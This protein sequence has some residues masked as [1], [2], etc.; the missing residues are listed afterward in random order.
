[1]KLPIISKVLFPLLISLFVVTDINLL[2]Q[3]PIE[4]RGNQKYRRRGLMNGNL[5]HTLF[6]NYCEVG[7][8]PADPSGSWPTPEAHY[9]DGI[10]L[11]VSVEVKN[12]KGVLIHPM[13][14]QYRE[15]V[16]SGCVIEKIL[17]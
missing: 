10:P 6:W 13:E 4:F 1:M 7:S 8:Y 15:F 12:S 3:S 16:P 5:V 14:T 11:V 9:L 2:A 17:C